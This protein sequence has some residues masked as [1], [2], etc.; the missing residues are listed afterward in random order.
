MPLLIIITGHW[1]D[2]EK[3]DVSGGRGERGCDGWRGWGTDNDDPEWTVVTIELIDMGIPVED[4]RGVL[5]IDKEHLEWGCWGGCCDEG[6][7]GIA[8][9]SF[10]IW[11]ISWGTITPGIDFW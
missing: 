5:E 3:L 7:I 9:T 2:C 10:V 11:G 4:G 6:G 8:G 1:I